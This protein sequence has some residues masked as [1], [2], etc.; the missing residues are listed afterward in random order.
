VP[1]ADAGVSM[2]TP[3]RKWASRCFRKPF[4]AAATR[5]RKLLGL[6]SL[7][8]EALGNT[9]FVLSAFINVNLRQMIL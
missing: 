6:Q 1:K 7:T 3:I 9:G 8:N 2:T 5:R 4:H